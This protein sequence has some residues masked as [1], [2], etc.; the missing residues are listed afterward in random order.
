MHA[1]QSRFFNGLVRI[2]VICCTALLLL[3]ATQAVAQFAASRPEWIWCEGDV[4]KVPTGSCHFR[5]TFD[6]TD[7]KSASIH[8]AAY[9]QFELFVNGKRV[10]EGNKDGALVDISDYL[11]AG[12]NTVA[13][14]VEKSS[15]I[16]GGLW[17]LLE[18]HP[19]IGQSTKLVT[20]GSW[21]ASPKAL[22][23]W[24]K[25]F[26]SDSKWRAARSLSRIVAKQSDDSKPDESRIAAVDDE[27]AREEPPKASKKLDKDKPSP[28][29]VFQGIDR[30]KL[31]KPSF[32]V[33]DGFHV[34]HIASHDNVGSIIAMTF[35]EFGEMII[36]SSGGSLRVVSDVNGDGTFDGVRNCCDVVKNVQGIVAV[37]G[38]LF[39]TG[40]GPVGSALYRLSDTDRNGDFENALPLVKFSGATG[41]HGPHAVV[42]GHDGLLYVLLGNHAEQPD[43]AKRGLYAN[44]YEGDIVPRM[45]DPGGHAN[46][47]KAPGGMVVR[48]DPTTGE[49]ESFAGGLRNPYD[50]AVNTFGH[51]FTH[52]SDMESD[53]GTTWYRPTKLFHVSAGAEFGWRS[54]W[55][56][57]PDYYVDA[58]PSIADTGRGSPTGIVFYEHTAFPK[59]YHGAM[60]SGDWTG[61]RIL[62]CHCQQNGAGYSA[63]T[64]TFLQ[65]QPLNVT[66]LEVGPDG[67]LYFCTG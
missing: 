9:D 48:V 16:N 31:E 53:E 4:S 47:V 65:G 2:R 46:G 49:A 14:K 63:E 23:L 21:R 50:L 64:S 15:T 12:E 61:G 55:A 51:L 20:D 44:W 38:D 10:G 36:S 5:K 18:I 59:Q 17:A 56:K 66:D 40:E 37:N 27:K 67:S 30:S 34:E 6:V 13:V 42:L 11:I 39:V 54:G 25:P 26:Y 57:W 52:D 60:F 29:L 24:Q 22:P 35:N 19:K 43:S 33:P 62:V 45:E 8:I 41:E 58:V 32:E 3:I 28:K 1:Y 7:V